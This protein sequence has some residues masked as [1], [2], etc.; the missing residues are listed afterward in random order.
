MMRAIMYGSQYKFI[1]PIFSCAYMS[2]ERAKL[3]G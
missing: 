1:L 2:V 3:H